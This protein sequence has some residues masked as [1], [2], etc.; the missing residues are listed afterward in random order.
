MD[1]QASPDNSQLYTRLS[2]ALPS[3]KGLAILMVV[4]YHIWNYTKDYPSFAQIIAAASNGSLKDWLE[5]CL[6]LVSLLG[7]QGV[8]FFLI[9]SGFGLAASWWRQYGLLDKK[10]S[11]FAVIPFWKRRLQKLLPFYW[12]AHALA[13]LLVFIHAE[14]VPFGH[15]VFNHSSLGVIAAVIASLTTLRNIVPEFYSFLN[16]AWWYVGLSVQLYLVFPLLINLGKR[17]GWTPLLM[18]SL[19]LSCL[20]R[21]VVITLP[22]SEKLTDVLV[23]G[24]LFPSRLFEF[25]FGIVLAISLLKPIATSQRRTTQIFGLDPNLFTW[26][27]ALLRKRQWLPVSVALWISG[28]ACHWSSSAG[29]LFLRVPADALIGV[30]EFC[31]VFQ[32]LAFAPQL[33]PWLKPLGHYSYGIYLT[34]MNLFVGLWALSLPLLPSY[35]PHLLLVTSIT[36]GLGGLLELGYQR[37]EEQFWLKKA[38]GRV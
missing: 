25:V 27:H 38:V 18:G 6:D 34:H 24:A 29:W 33:Q 37:L 36:C 15:E 31:L 7:E 19:L 8:H 30:G 5:A 10:A 32:M 4:I 2:Q 17:W 3:I 21:A 11:S 20:Y 1:S 26:I 35:W 22:L 13:L 28:L 12:A 16:G 9:A 14:W 23:R